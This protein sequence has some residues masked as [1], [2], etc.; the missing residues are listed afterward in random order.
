MAVEDLKFNTTEGQ[1]IAREMMISYLN[2][3][4]SEL[5]KWAPIGRRTNSA[6]IEMDWSKNSEQDVLG[7]TWTTMKKPVKTQTFDPVPLDAGDPVG[8]KLWNLGIRDEDAQALANMDVLI[9]HFYVDS[10]EEFFSERYSGCAISLT[11]IGGEG[12]GNLEISSEIT[13]GGTRTLG[14]IS[15]GEGGEITFTADGA[16]V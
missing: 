11:R 10:A 15:R 6:D 9:G 2:V 8:V 14:H 4:T 3:G 12:G 16:G 5:P 13:Y 1:T 7:D